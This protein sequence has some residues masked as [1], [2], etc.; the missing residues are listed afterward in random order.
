[1]AYSLHRYIGMLAVYGATTLA[2][3]AGCV[4]PAPLNLEGADAGPGSPPIILTSGPAPEFSFPGPLVLDRSENPLLSLTVRDNDL[5][6]ELYVRLYVDY[7]LPD[8]RPARS[9]CVIP[10]SG[11]LERVGQCAVTPV[12]GDIPN[13]DEEV[14]YLEA[15]IADRAFLEETDRPPEQ[16][17]HRGLPATAASSIRAWM[18]RCL[19]AEQ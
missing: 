7:G 2:L 6:D 19:P 4:W 13:D 3:G 11:E 1:M 14:H 8:Q 15:V 10:P 5:E 17:P 12:C 9:G 18:V 16:L